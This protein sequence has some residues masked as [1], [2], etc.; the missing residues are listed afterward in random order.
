LLLVTL[1]AGLI[2][3]SLVVVLG[4]LGGHHHGEDPDLSPVLLE[5]EDL[6]LGVNPDRHVS[7]VKELVVI[8]RNAYVDVDLHL[9]HVASL[10]L[11][12]LHWL[13]KIG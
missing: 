7:P 1:E 10:F 2:Q 9:A 3:L 13:N 4:L 5:L 6:V 8:A 12:L 11:D